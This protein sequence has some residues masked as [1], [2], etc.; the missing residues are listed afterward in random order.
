MCTKKTKKKMTHSQLEKG[1]DNKLRMANVVYFKIR[2]SSRIFVF[3]IQ[4]NNTNNSNNYN[5]LNYY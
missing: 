2:G 3:F 4:I 1:T 5:N